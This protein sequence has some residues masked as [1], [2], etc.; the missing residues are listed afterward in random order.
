MVEGA[1][2]P[3]RLLDPQLVG[4]LRL[5]QLYAETLTQLVLMRTPC[6]P[7][8]FDV[9]LVWRQQSLEDLDGRRLAG[10]VR[11]Q[12]PE[13][14]AALDGQ[15]EPVDG[16]DVSIALANVLAPQR[17]SVGHV[18]HSVRL[19]APGR[20]HVFELDWR[21]VSATVLIASPEHLQVLKARED[22]AN[23]QAFADAEALRALD[24]ITRQRPDIVALEKLFAS[25][26]RGTALINRIK[27]DPS[28]AACE[29]RIV[30]HDSEPARSP[31]RPA[32]SAA[33]AA[34]A[35]VEAPPAAPAK[36]PLD[37]RGTR[38]APRF[39]I[40]DG[41]EVSIDGKPATLQD[42]SLVGAM[43]VSP[44]ILRPNQRVRMSLPDTNRPVRFSGGVAWALFEMPRGG[45]RYRAGIEFFDADPVA[46]NKFIEKNKK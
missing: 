27:A 3:Q 40:L 37:Q 2:E 44:T 23:A 17:E 4:E 30:A 16:D 29:I 36:A 42:L 31:S 35:V 15:R 43:V 22:L 34:V 1:K 25:T 13:A 10:A 21:A 9:A 19:L 38:R 33:E 14:L 5:L 41:V 26:S 18:S 11:T 39:E 46:L 8:H 20:W 45:P 7:E 32:Q 6:H 28:L 24:V 12:Q